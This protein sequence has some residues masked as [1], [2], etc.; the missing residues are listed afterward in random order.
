MRFII[1]LCALLC[2]AFSLPLPIVSSKRA[3]AAGGGSGPDLIHWPLNDGAGTSIAA[4][5][6]PNGTTD[7][8]L[9]S[10][11]L[12]FTTDDDAQSNSSVTYG[13]PSCTVMYWIYVTSWAA[14]SE[15]VHVESGP[16]YA[17]AN[18]RFSIS[19][20][21]STFTV[22]LANDFFGAGGTRDETFSTAVEGLSDATWYHV[23]V[24]VDQNA[25]ANAG[26]IK[27]YINATEITLSLGSNTKAGAGAANIATDILHLGARNAASGFLGGRMDDLRIY[28]GEKDSA[29]INTIIGPGRP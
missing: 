23:A 5:V 16:T 4:S 6:G 17:D 22:H 29:F 1:S 12:A 8:T 28:S 25:N 20:S 7:G 21:A 24:F 9:N 27:V 14:G 3:A 18:A 19:H 10:D 11:Y 26:E 13:S 15:N 2:V